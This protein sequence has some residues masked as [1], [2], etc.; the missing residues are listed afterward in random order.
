MSYNQHDWNA[1]NHDQDASNHWANGNYSAYWDAAQDANYARAQA[2]WQRDAEAR[3]AAQIAEWSKPI[4]G[5]ATQGGAYSGGYSGGYH[6]GSS[7]S[8]PG[9]DVLWWRWVQAWGRGIVADYHTVIGRPATPKSAA[10]G[11][12][13]RIWTAV[14]APFTFSGN[15]IKALLGLPFAVFFVFLRAIGL[16]LMLAW[17]LFKIVFVMGTLAGLGLWGAH[18]AGWWD[19][20]VP[21]AAQHWVAE[22]TGTAIPSN[23][24]H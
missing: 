23:L 12:G 5:A 3:S 6:G 21:P 10:P 22:I 20:E 24:L 17:F 14:R 2:Q 7:S 9:W 16:A 15:L 11:I 1:K 13:R 19:G 4:G 18:A 8:G